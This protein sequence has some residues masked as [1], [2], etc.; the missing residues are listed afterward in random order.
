[1]AVPLLLLA[2]T[3]AASSP[4]ALITA[5]R[6]LKVLAPSRPRVAESPTTNK[7][8]ITGIKVAA[9]VRDAMPEST[10][11]TAAKVATAA[12]IRPYHRAGPEEE[13][14][15]RN[16]AGAARMPPRSAL[17]MR[18]GGAPTY[19]APACVRD[20]QSRGFHQQFLFR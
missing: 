18:P 10:A 13:S 1:M 15:L 19:C 5:L 20:A 11:S 7:A 12:V 8:A 2:M 16:T 3:A 14:R 6:L 9:R 17:G 4:A